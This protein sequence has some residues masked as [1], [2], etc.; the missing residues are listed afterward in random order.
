MYIEKDGLD[1]VIDLESDE[2]L[3]LFVPT[4]MGRT[5]VHLEVTSSGKLQITGGS[6]IIEGII[7]Q[8]MAEKVKHN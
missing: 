8:G 6:S 4:S 1:C 7:G 2:R 5:C 3:Q